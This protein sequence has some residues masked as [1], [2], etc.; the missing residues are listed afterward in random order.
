MAAVRR[1][2]ELPS[3]ELGFNFD[4]TNDE[5]VYSV[6]SVYLGSPAEKAGV[7][8]GDKIFTIN[9]SAIIDANYWS[10]VWMRNHP[11]DTVRLGI[12]RP[13]VK[14]AISISG[15]FRLRQSTT[16]EGSLEYFASEVRNSFPVPFVLVG[17]T[18]LFLRLEDPTVWLLALLF[19]SFAATPSIPNELAISPTLRALV[20]AYRAIFSSM[21]GP[22][23]YFFFA[24]FP[25]RSLID[26][27][28]P[29]LKWGLIAIGI[30]LALPGLQAG[31]MQLP[32][33]LVKLLG[34]SASGKVIFI[35]TFVM[36]ILGLVSFAL[37]FT[38][39]RDAEAR[40]KIRVILWGT[41]VGLAPIL[42]EAGAES[43][44]SFQA[45]TWLSTALIALLFLFP[46]SF[47][48]AVVRHRVLDIPI[49]LRRG[50]R[51]L[52]VQRG[53]TFLLSLASIGLILI[54]AL[55]LSRYLEPSTLITEPYAIALGSVFGTLLLWGG[56]RVHRRVSGRIDRAFFR[57]AYDARLIMEDLARR[58]AIVT[59]R[60]ELARLLEQHLKEALQPS[61]LFIYFRAND[62]HLAA[63]SGTVPPELETISSELPLLVELAKRDQP[64]EYRSEREHVSVQRSSLDT[65]QPDCLVPMVGHGGRLLGL[66]V[67]GQRLSEELYSGED[68]R[69]L[70]SVASQ[71]A[72]AL[73]NIHLAEEIAERIETERRVEREMEIAKEVQSRLLPQS[74][75]RLK[76]LDLAAQCVQARSVGG[77][78]YDFLDLGP[79]RM[80]FVLGDVSGKGIHAALLMA[81]LQAHIRS[82]TGIAPNDPVRALQ[83]VN[84]M[85]WQ[86]TSSRHFA[87]LFFGIYE[88]S[89]RR[90]VYVNCGQNPPVL[91][92]RDGTVQRL[93]PTAAVIGVFQKWEC[94]V[95]EIELAPDDLLVVYSDG[96]TEA[97]S[98]EDQFGEA[99]LIDVLRA[100]RGLPVNEI[101]AAIL[102]SVQR[103][104]G[105]TQS[106]DLT[107]LVARAR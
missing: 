88:E 47:A 90:V 68:R 103:F 55:S 99:R 37:N 6:T 27:R 76:T 66:L 98:K 101:V 54:F 84:R 14:A 28:L 65:L 18:V 24:V 46:L 71:A 25:T 78:Y 83:Q 81:S 3:V 79:D 97:A 19:G 8:T 33:P 20:L 61:S 34:T 89:T 75:P 41:A 16:S 107:L 23:F 11:G 53:F 35:C 59:D 56:T 2:P 87:T 26:R 63:A 1:G 22:L 96:I 73:E 36:L 57:N 38:R 91:L 64:L 104:S 67:L 9:D 50:A 42:A 69:L 30:G 74:P 62:G 4:F 82:Q 106:D 7:L 93:A 72:S 44:F 77:D 60:D 48:Y 32:S 29:W 51:Y 49:L 105:G 94:S 40:R 102:T 80:G 10:K 39:T 100:N 52:L 86:S 31:Q 15:V 43:L 45:L 21:L 85:L 12:H 95:G 58:T 70:A 5:R 13:G 17:L 92:R